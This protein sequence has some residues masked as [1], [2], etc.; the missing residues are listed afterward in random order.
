[1]G[2]MPQ[3]NWAMKRIENSRWAMGALAATVVVAA[4]GLAVSLLRT[5]SGGSGPFGLVGVALGLLGLL[6][7]RRAR[8]AVGWFFLVAGLSIALSSLTDGYIHFAVRGRPEPLPGASVAGW[9]NNIVFALLAAPL[10]LI[11]LVFPT[12]RIPSPRWRPVVW[13]WAGGFMG[14]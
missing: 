9:V 6:I 10:P 12:G 11:F 14:M 2:E 7:V 4:A 5:Q 13:L 1:M 8:N 3:H